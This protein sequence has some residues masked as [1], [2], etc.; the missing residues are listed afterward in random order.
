MLRERAT[1]KNYR[2]VSLLFV[3]KIFEKLVNN[4]LV[5]IVE[6]CDP[7]SDFHYGF[8][9]SCSTADLL[10]VV[11]DRISRASNR[12]RTARVEA[13]DLSKAFDRVC[14]TLFFFTV[15]SIIEFQVRVLTSFG[16]F[17]VGDGFGWFWMESLFKSVVFLKGQFLVL[18]FSCYTLIAIL[19]IVFV[20]LCAIWYQL[21]NLKNVKN[22]H[23]GV[24]LLVTLQA[25]SVPFVILL[26]LC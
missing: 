26:S 10:T 22:T 23:G 17:L 3:G 6:N 16:H 4:R 9:F 25:Q 7:I 5:D 11:S 18:R 20:M 19:T 14:S 12:F 8:R 24:L 21:Y 13:S 15:S 2:L 1:T